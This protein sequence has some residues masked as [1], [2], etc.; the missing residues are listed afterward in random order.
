M[1]HHFSV[2]MK[3]YSREKHVKSGSTTET[4]AFIK[5][6]VDTPLFSGV[7]FYLYTGKML[8]EKRASIEIVF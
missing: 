5:L 2:N 1:K 6:Y 4:L 3:D 7:P 8:D